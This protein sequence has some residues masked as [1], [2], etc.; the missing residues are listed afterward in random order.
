MVLDMVVHFPVKDTENRVHIEGAAIEAMVE[1]VLG[2]PGVVGRPKM[3]PSH[4]P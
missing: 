1:N 4:A 3:T 2:Q